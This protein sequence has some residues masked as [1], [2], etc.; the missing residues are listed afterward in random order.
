[1]KRILTLSLLLA[2]VFSGVASAQANS[3][4]RLADRLLASDHI[5]VDLSY[6]TDTIGGRPTGTLANL[7]S[8]EWAVE[9]FEEAGVKVWKESFI[10]PGL[11]LGKSASGVISGDAGFSV[12]LAAMPFSVG[13]GEEAV[14]ARLLD[15][16]RG[17]D[18]DFARLGEAASGAFVLIETEPL[19][20][21][22]GLFRE[23]TEAAAIEKRSLAAGVRGLVYMGSRPEDV[24]YRHN[25]SLGTDNQQLLLIMERASAWRALRLLR[26]GAD[27]ALQ[28][29]VEVVSAGPYESFNVIAEIPGSEK[30]D[31]VVVIG[32]HL[33]SWGL[34]TGAL[35]NGGNCAMLIDI[36]RQMVAAG[37]QPKRTIRF[38]LWNGEEQ[39]LQGSLGYV[40]RHRDELDQHVMAS[41]Y[42]IGTGKIVG[43]FTGGR[44]EVAA[45]TESAV[46]GL[47]DLAA[48]DWG[49]FAMVDMP[50]VGTDNYDFMME[51]VP[52][53]VANQESANYG[54]NY[55]ASTD[56]FDKVDI[57]QMKKNAVIA[58]TVTLAFANQDFDLPR[59]SRAEIEDLIET[60]SLGDQMRTFNVYD[61]WKSGERGR[62][63]E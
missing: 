30:P 7:A 9:R 35:D 56:T 16:G 55:H 1:M 19:T 41:S 45:A 62:A 57:E 42:D 5:G 6:L 51:G 54:P 24:L 63:A 23:Y 29:E 36:A 20:D 13:T 50:V 58:A 34:G 10:M 17:T 22:P 60:T 37:I 3:V 44:P 25:A 31:E 12:R 21:V 48:L 52:N 49:P 59:Q 11:W 38:A 53:L 47:D 15:G 26:G 4:D 2:T 18:E 61:K 8:V 43:F 33:D 40:R 27:L 14:E 32:A 28:V 46:A 39:G